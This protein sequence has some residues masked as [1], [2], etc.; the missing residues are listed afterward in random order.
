MSLQDNGSEAIISEE[1]VLEELSEGIDDPMVLK[2]QLAKE[3]E[4][5]RQLTARAKKAEAEV[6]E[7]KEKLLRLEK[8]PDSRE[9]FTKTEYSLN[10]EVV[11]LRLE[12]YS[13][14]DVGFIMNNGGRKSLDDKNSY[15]AIAIKARKEQTKAEAEAQKVP[16]TSGISEVERKYTPEMLRNMSAAELKK[17]LPRT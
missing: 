4:A 14:D 9:S 15:V 13:K 8:N 5:R 11:D 2:E 3:L 12:G 10:D 1:I 16:D 17:I 7:A 6:R